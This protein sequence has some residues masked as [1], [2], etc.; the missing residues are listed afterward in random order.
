MCNKK[1]IEILQGRSAGEMNEFTQTALTAT[2][3]GL[4]AIN[5]LDTRVTEPILI[6]QIIHPEMTS[7]F[8]GKKSI[9]EMMEYL[10]DYLTKQEKEMAD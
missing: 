10:T 7:V 8:L 3:D 6:R 9:D 5:T 1:Y 4:P 2:N